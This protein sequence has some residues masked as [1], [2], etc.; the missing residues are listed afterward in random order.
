[1]CEDK[2]YISPPPDAEGPYEYYLLGNTRPVR[3]ICNER[4]LTV[5][6]E[7]PDLD[8][9]GALKINNVLISRILSSPEVEAI[10]R[11]QFVELCQRAAL[12]KA[13]RN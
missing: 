8:D 1:M 6:A 11:D 12:A 5:G 10:T 7:A 4:G 2:P 3:V 9:S 13:E